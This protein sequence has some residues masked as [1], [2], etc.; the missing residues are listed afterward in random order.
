MPIANIHDASAHELGTHIRNL[1][2][3]I[4][5]L[6]GQIEP[7]GRA[8]ARTIKIVRSTI[9]MAGGLLTATAIDMLGLILTF[10]GCW[11]CVEVVVEDAREMNRQHAVRRLLT[12]L[13]AE[14]DAAESELSRRLP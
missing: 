3:R 10:L 11:D 13:S 2:I 1:S 12:Q 14:I 9:L 8:R 7:R 5:R 4:A 6:E